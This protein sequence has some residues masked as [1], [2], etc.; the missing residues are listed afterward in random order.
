MECQSQSNSQEIDNLKKSLSALEAKEKSSQEDLN[1]RKLEAEELQ[2]K[3]CGLEKDRKDL[4]IT[5]EA[6]QK[7]IGEVKQEYEKIVEWKNEKAQLI[8]NVESDRN[9]MQSK[10]DELEKTSVTLDD[11]NK[12]LQ[13]KLQ[14][15]D[16]E[17]QSQIDS[18]KG[19]LLNKC[20]E[21][22][23]KS[24]KYEEMVQKYNEANQKHAKDAENTMAQIKMLQDQVRDL[25]MRLQVETNKTARM[26]QSHSEL[27]A[28]YESACDLAKSKDAIIELNQNEIAH[29][30]ESV[31]HSNAKQEQL[32]EKFEVEKSALVKEYEGNLAEKSNEAEQA[33]LNLIR[34]EQDILLLQ[35]QVTSVE[36][37]LRFQKGLS[38]ELQAKHA[39][40]LKVN[41]DLS[42][43]ICEA[44]NREAEL[45]NEVKVLS[46][47]MKSLNAL[48]DQ[49]TAFAAAAEESKLALENLQETHKQTVEELQAQ[50]TRLEK[51][52][53]KMREVEN[54]VSNLEREN[55]ELTDNLERA[56]K[57][58]DDLSS[59]YQTMS[60]THNVICAENLDLQSRISTISAELTEK[61]GM[62]ETLNSDLQ[63]SNVLCAELKI[64]V[65]SLQKQHD[66]VVGLN[67]KLKKSL[68]EKTDSIGSL[69]ADVKE[70]SEKLTMAAE[71]HVAEMEKH[72]Q[73]HKNLKEQLDVV[74]AQ[75]QEK[76]QEATE[77][78]GKMASYQTEISKLKE[79][80][81]GSNSKLKEVSEINVGISQELASCKQSAQE[82]LQA[83]AQ[84]LETLRVALD[85]SK[86]NEESKHSEIQKLQDQLNEAELEKSKSSDALKEKNINLNKIKVQ[87]EMLQ[88]DLEDNEACITSYDSQI[89]ELKGTVSILEEKLDETKAQRSNLEVALSSAQ[90]QLS[91]KTSEIS[92]LNASLEDTHKQQHNNLTLTAE[93]Q[94][95]Q[96]ANESLKMSLEAEVCKRTNIETIHNSLTEQKRKMEKDLLELQRDY[97]NALDGLDSLNQKNDGLQ[98]V[99]QNLTDET[100]TLKGA[101][102][103]ARQQM[104][105]TSVKNK[106][107]E[108]E[109]TKLSQQIVMLQ[110]EQSQ[111]SDQYS[112]LLTQVVEQQSLIEQLKDN[113][114]Q[115]GTPNSNDEF[116]QEH[117]VEENVGAGQPVVENLEICTPVEDLF[118]P[119]I[120]SAHESL[121]TKTKALKRSETVIESDDHVSIEE[122]LQVKSQELEELSNAFEEAV[123]TLEEQREVQLEQL[124][125]QHTS[126]L[127]TL[128]QKMDSVKLDL[129][130]K[131]VHERQHS[132]MLSSQ[133]EMATQQLEELN[134][135]S[136]TLMLDDQDNF[137][138]VSH[139]VKKAACENSLFTLMH[140]DAMPHVILHIGI[141]FVV[142]IFY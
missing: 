89:E 95:L 88:M 77:V 99:I 137:P 91:T 93:L 76:C 129:E 51:F 78:E 20:M 96:K 115:A 16:R 40:L 23:E 133:L 109:H 27:L 104:E 94:S 2:N 6:K 123:R 52:E 69:E 19:E 120:S 85:I 61:V 100:Q 68:E 106:E 32:L 62:L 84:D 18:L 135:A 60:E 47:Q 98:E 45:L 65:E 12:C 139:I 39:D 92:Q 125:V 66:A 112:H 55:T 119:L 26:E 134:L 35:D 105:N 130:A 24:C 132:E 53:I 127:Q 48:Q 118:S 34:C 67:S 74:K 38:A 64:S 21:L 33:K 86:S 42:Q 87:L 50:K 59:M 54:D 82:Q 141:H 15:L 36:S 43:K 49:C 10:I 81:A 75:L 101:L 30:H 8:E 56:E 37:A 41:E 73:K 114:N 124:R 17:K 113:K 121:D 142:C 83:R 46:D 29:L 131:L 31:S 1:K 14:D 4:Q 79:D 63:A 28:Q 70:I 110:K 136:Q 9:A 126:E 138:Q 111:F 107:F 25:E 117:V 102:E 7:E 122:Q 116:H 97:Q 72:L 80:L 140:I 3:L 90:E 108:E 103:Q 44:Q 57:E 22:E 58:K 11:A 13:Q 128:Q 5:A 71:S